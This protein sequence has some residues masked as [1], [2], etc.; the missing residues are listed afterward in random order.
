VCQSVWKPLRTRS[1]MYRHQ[2][3]LHVCG[4]H[5]HFGLPCGLWSQFTM[6]ARRQWIQL[7][8]QHRLFPNTAIPW[9]CRPTLASNDGFSSHLQQ[10]RC[11]R[12][13]SIGARHEACFADDT[14]THI[15]RIQFFIFYCWLHFLFGSLC[16]SRQ[17]CIITTVLV[18]LSLDTD[19]CI[20]RDLVESIKVDQ[21]FEL[22]QIIIK[23]S[24]ARLRPVKL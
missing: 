15:H 16:V 14:T 4:S 20:R 6:C 9:M 18:L 23:A 21:S 1:R 22:L 5:Q 7:R 19:L 13:L 12:I 8:V 11:N 3:R 17:N 24:R 2:F 10:H